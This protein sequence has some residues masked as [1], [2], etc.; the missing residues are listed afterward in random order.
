MA[1]E[2]FPTSHTPHHAPARDHYE[3]RNT[4]EYNQEQPPP[5]YSLQ[6]SQFICK[7]PDLK[8]GKKRGRR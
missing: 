5:D 8:A 7:V 6:L 4:R 1:P 2:K 3:Q